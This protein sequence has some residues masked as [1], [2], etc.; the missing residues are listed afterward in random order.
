MLE[1]GDDAAEAREL[2][3]RMQELREEET[4]LSEREQTQL[5]EFLTPGQV[6]RFQA[7]REEMGQRIRRLRGGGPGGPGGSVGPSGGDPFFPER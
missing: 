2:L 1:G 6:L 5:L 7:L 4:R 3:D